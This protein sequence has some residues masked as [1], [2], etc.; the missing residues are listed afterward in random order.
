M[1]RAISGKG[2]RG[3]LLATNALA[4]ASPVL[5]CLA[6]LGILEVWGVGRVEGIL[7]EQDTW[8]RNWQRLLGDRETED[9]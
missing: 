5:R 4:A 6:L 2:L 9:N 3:E 7:L 8:R 1:L